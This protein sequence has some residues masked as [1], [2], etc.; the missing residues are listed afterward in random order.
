[1]VRESPRGG[2]PTASGA[3]PSGL[4]A[5]RATLAHEFNNPL[6]IIT[7]N[8][9]FAL[10]GLKTGSELHAAIR[11]AREATGRLSKLVAETFDVPVIQPEDVPSS[12]VERRGFDR[13]EPGS[14]A[15]PR[16]ARVLVVDDEPSIGA[17]LRRSLRD[18]D[19]VVTVNGL[20]ALA[21]IAHGE[22]FDIILCDLTM[23]GMG[24]DDVF[25]EIQRVAPDQAE[26]MVFITGGATT[27][28]AEEFIDNVPNH[29]LH[30]P[31]EVS[32]LREMIRTRL[33]ARRT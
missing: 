13:A 27:E 29:V 20:E 6:A 2:V 12:S 7:T 30:K 23:P 24:G 8:L 11:D 17:A 31:F 26:R 22:R 32:T 28:S 21:Q 14:G 5:Q 3:P 25:R 4:D 19:V 9:D 1:M 18:Y 16:V 15:L 10:A 33:A